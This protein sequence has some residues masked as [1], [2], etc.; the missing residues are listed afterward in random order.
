MN[1][2]HSFAKNCP[3]SPVPLGD[4]RKCITPDSVQGLLLALYS[5]SAFLVLLNGLYVVPDIEAR[6]ALSKTNTLTPQQ[7]LLKSFLSPLICA[8]FVSLISLMLVTYYFYYYRYTID[9]VSKNTTGFLITFTLNLY[10]SWN[11]NSIMNIFM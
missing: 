5:I 7:L 2:F 9:V 10:N 4:R 1:Q 11:I 6:P 8:Y 3:V